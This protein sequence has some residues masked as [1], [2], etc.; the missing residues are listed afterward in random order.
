MKI[1]MLI[2]M[3]SLTTSLMADTTLTYTDKTDK[4]SMKMQLANNKMRATSVD[5]N[6]SYMVYDANNT[7]FTMY[8]TDKKQYFVM[9]E[10]EIAALS[11]I[12]AMM[13]KILEKQ[14]AEMPESQ[15]EM[16]RGMMTKMVKSQMPKQVEKAEYSLTGKSASYNGVDCQIAIK[17]SKRKK[18]EFCVTHYKDLDMDADEF[19]VITSFQHTIE[20][21]ARQYGDDNSMDFSSLG[22]FIPVRYKQSGE[23]GTLKDV[24]HDKLNTAIFAIPEGYTKMDM[25][26]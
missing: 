18:S 1:I 26:F 5:D 16:M 25:P 19:A 2:L 23:S 7:T 4:V 3:S 10:K 6:S 14:L 20:A 8:M 17:K 13:D 9:G 24:N 15:R 11:D 21:L 22:D 12:G